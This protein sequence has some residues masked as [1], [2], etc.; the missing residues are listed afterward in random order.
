[1]RPLVHPLVRVPL[2]TEP[3][4][5][6]PERPQDQGPGRVPVPERPQDQGPMQGPQSPVAVPGGLELDR[7]GQARMP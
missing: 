3:Q 7:A 4:G 5:R 6:Q 2:P 1:M